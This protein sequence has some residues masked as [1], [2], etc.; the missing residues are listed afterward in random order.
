MG[1]RGRDG[2]RMSWGGLVLGGGASPFRFGDFHVLVQHPI[3]SFSLGFVNYMK[4]FLLFIVLGL[5]Y[6]VNRCVPSGK[7]V[8]VSLRW[9]KQA[10]P[11]VGHVMISPHPSLN[12]SSA[13]TIEF[14]G[15]FSCFFFLSIKMATVVRDLSAP[16]VLF[17]FF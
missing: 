1:V 3:C 15:F 9:Q 7:G 17:F 2:C 5:L 8:R 13:I 10:G 12:W 14:F 6:I 4:Y 11:K 16:L